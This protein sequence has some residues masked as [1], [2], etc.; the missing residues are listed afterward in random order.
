MDETLSK[1]REEQLQIASK[2]LIVDDN[3]S[4]L[5]NCQGKSNKF[6]RARLSQSIKDKLIGG[7]DVSFGEDDRAIAVYV[8]TRNHEKEEHPNLTP[9][10]ILV[11]GNGILHE[12]KAG[13][14]TF[15]GVRTNIPTIGIGKTLYCTDGFSLDIVNKGV[16]AKLV[17]Y[18]EQQDFDASME[19]L[20]TEPWCI[21]SRDP[22]SPNEKSM[23]EGETG[24]EG[25]GHSMSDLIKA[26]S[27]QCEGFAIPLKGVSGEVLAAVLV[28]HGG[29]ITNKKQQ[30]TK[31][32]IYI[33]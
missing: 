10:V 20:S 26:I 1:W 15:V 17:E 9:E 19:V 32:P 4:E 12:R 28:G 6:S 8:I 3:V 27:A 16:N 23:N 14:A 29:N 25:G 33:S 30:G 18:L 13:L 21:I 2:L 5:E 24:K 11:D 7:V 22:I 31:I